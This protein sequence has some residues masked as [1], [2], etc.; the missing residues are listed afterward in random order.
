[1][2][3]SDYSMRNATSKTVLIAQL[4]ECTL[5]EQEVVGLFLSSNIPMIPVARLLGAQQVEL[6]SYSQ[7][8]WEKK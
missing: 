6:A 7:K 8:E 1:M 5:R 4:L 3:K 2:V